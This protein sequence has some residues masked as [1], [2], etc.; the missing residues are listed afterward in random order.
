MYLNYAELIQEDPGELARLERRYRSGPLADRLT[1]LRLL[2]SGA[3]RSRRAL[4]DVLGYSERHLHRWFATYREGGLTALMAH[5]RPSGRAE[6]VTP[7]AWAALEEEMRAGR[8]AGLKQAQRFLEERFSTSYTIG[9]LSD[10]FRRKKTKLKTGRRRNKK[11]S[12]EEQ[13]AFKKPVP[14]SR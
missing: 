8:I 9:G 7:E 12:L 13:A 4:S 5:E 2:K 3:Y 14:G 1:M 6:R 11:A 10:L